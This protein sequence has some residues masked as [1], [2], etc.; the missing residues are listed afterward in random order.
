MI[1]VD[2]KQPI[3]KNDLDLKLLLISRFTFV[4]NWQEF[5]DIQMTVAHRVGEIMTL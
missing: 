2:L 3:P 4:V 1:L 5:A